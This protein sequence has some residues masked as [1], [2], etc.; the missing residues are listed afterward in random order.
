MPP[1][2]PA[3]EGVEE[4]VGDG[5]DI[6]VGLSEGEAADDGVQAGG[7]G[8]IVEVVGDVGFMDDTSQLVEDRIFE[9]V[10]IEDGLEG[11][12]VAVVGELD[13]D[14]VERGGV[15]R[16]VV[17]IVNEDEHSLGVNKPVDEPGRSGPV[18]MD[19]G[20]GGPPQGAVSGSRL[21]ASR[22]MAFLASSFSGVEK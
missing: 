3:I 20:A 6:G 7:F 1:V 4:L 2:E 9:A 13:S 8:G 12:V 16:H 11:D 22:S 18:D 21:A 14:H 17:G 10:P 19:P 5:E 15:G